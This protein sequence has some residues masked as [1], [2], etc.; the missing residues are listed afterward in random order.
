MFHLAYSQPPHP[1]PPQEL[2]LTSVFDLARYGDVQ[3]AYDGLLFVGTQI[4]PPGQ[5]ALEL[6]A[7]NTRRTVLLG[8]GSTVQNVD[9]SFLPLHGLS[10]F[11]SARTGSI[12]P[13]NRSIRVLF[14]HS[15]INKPRFS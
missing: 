1:L 15:Y 13:E 8:D 5:A 7:E 12:F 14:S 2:I 3:L 10:A 9:P 11:N 4:R 6:E